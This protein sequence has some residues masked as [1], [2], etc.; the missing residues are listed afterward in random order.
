MKS[1]RYLVPCVA[2]MLLAA[3]AFAVPA[4]TNLFAIQLSNGTADLYDRGDHY[5][6]AYDHSELGGQLQ[7]WHVMP[8]DLA[9]ALSGGVGFFSETDKPGNN[10]PPGSQ[11]FKYTQSSWNVRLGFDRL[12]EIGDRTIFYFGPGL[13]YWSG[14]AKFDYGTGDPANWES[15]NVTRFAISGRVGGMMK[16]SEQLAFACQVGR[17]VG[18][19]SADDEGRKASWWPS[20][21]EAAGG[22]VFGFGRR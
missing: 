16:V 6:T 18:I 7:L 15:K 12:A 2:G 13:E 11:D 10:P 1:L 22:L 9:V 3:N 20:G 5:I 14:K 8:N 17:Y 21:L 4:G 19:A